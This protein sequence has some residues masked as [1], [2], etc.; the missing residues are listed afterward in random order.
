[1]LDGK[2]NRIYRPLVDAAWRVHCGRTAG[3]DLTDKIAKDRWY[4]KA[5]LDA[6]GIHTTKEIRQNDTTSFEAL[7]LHFAVIACDAEQIA[8][9]STAE[10]RRA[11]WGLEQNMKRAGLDWAYVKGI[12][13][14]MHLL[15]ANMMEIKDLPAE[16]IRK[17][18]VAL[19]LYIKRGARGHARR[20]E[21]A[22]PF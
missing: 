10:E 14:A 6:A 9:W 7:C 19:F 15:D 13:K 22:V 20:A 3:A 11:L 8:Y 2:Q 12:A 5:L 17:L 4:R 16:H 1:M 21:E 18:S